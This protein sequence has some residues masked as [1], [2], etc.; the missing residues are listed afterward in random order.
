MSNNSTFRKD[1]IQKSAELTSKNLDMVRLNNVTITREIK[2]KKVTVDKSKKKA[3]EDRVRHFQKKYLT[4]QE[5]PVSRRLFIK[6][7]GKGHKA[8]D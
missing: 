3:A 8:R 1:I 4:T 6:H 5:D 7:I 2:E